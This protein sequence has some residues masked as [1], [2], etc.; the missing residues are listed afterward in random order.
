MSLFESFNDTRNNKSYAHDN[1]IL[2][3]IESEFAIRNIVNTINFI[4][5]LETINEEKEF[6]L[7]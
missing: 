2:N 1:I 6:H 3:K 5:K 4:S 7:L